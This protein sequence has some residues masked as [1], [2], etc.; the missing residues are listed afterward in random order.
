MHNVSM[1]TKCT[2][3]YFDNNCR[4]WRREEEMLILFKE[5]TKSV[6]K[7]Y[8]VILY[9]LW[10]RTFINIINIIRTKI[11]RS[12]SNS[13]DC[14]PRTYFLLIIKTKYFGEM[15]HLKFQKSLF[16]PENYH[17]FEIK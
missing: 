15:S 8:V 10:K 2:V 17:A 11:I 16:I 5:E 13:S 3:L 12:Y 7:K 1:E 4:K 6:M 9:I 14:I